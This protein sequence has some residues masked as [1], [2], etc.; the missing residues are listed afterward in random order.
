MGFALTLTGMDSLRKA[1]DSLPAAMR[2]RVIVPAAKKAIK[3][4]EKAIV[5][6]I[7]INKNGMRRNGLGKQRRQLHYRT[8]MTSVVR[9]YPLSGSVVALAGAESGK[10]PHANLVEE[11][12]VQR[13][14]NSKPVYRKIATGVK[15]VLKRGKIVTNA[16]WDIVLRVE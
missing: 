8:S 14:T 1:L 10:A 7:P 16:T 5:S 3:I 11:G 9:E 2:H 15:S 12:T 13:F 4:V 6:R